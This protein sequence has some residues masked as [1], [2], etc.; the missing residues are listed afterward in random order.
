VRASTGAREPFARAQPSAAALL[1]GP[2]ARNGRVERSGASPPSV[3]EAGGGETHSIKFFRYVKYI[4]VF[5]QLRRLKQFM[6]GAPKCVDG[7]YSVE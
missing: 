7:G 1:P 2:F 4:N 3:V 5:S 6:H